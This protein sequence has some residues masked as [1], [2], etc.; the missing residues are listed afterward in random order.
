L[1]SEGASKK[2][3]TYPETATTKFVKQ[4]AE[5]SD[6][7]SEEA[8]EDSDEENEEIPLRENYSNASCPV[9]RPRKEYRGAAN[10]RTVKDGTYLYALEDALL[11][12]STK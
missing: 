12:T 7:D 8:S 10:V 6:L 1:D 4:D 2:Q 5:E 3:S 11:L 9:I